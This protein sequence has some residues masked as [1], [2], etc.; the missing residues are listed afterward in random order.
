MST[1]T[2][3]LRLQPRWAATAAAGGTAAGT[4]AAAMAVRTRG[5]DDFAACS[6]GMK[7]IDGASEAG[8][9]NLR[10]NDT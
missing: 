8:R 7:S 10:R 4:A 3:N 5:V 6:K 9:A 2:H 1:M